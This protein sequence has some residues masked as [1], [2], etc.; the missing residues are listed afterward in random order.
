MNSLEKLNAEELSILKNWYNSLTKRQKDIVI[1]GYSTKFAY[2]IIRLLEE[3]E[4][5]LVE[6]DLDLTK[7]KELLKSIRRGEWT[8]EQI[9]EYFK[10]KEKELNTVYLN[11]TLRH[12]PDEGKIKQLLIECIE[13]WYGD[14]S[15][16]VP[17]NTETNILNDLEQLIK[18]YSVNNENN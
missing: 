5:I 9:K 13:D 2:H 18:K 17:H 11:S 12:S 14:L 15:M 3:S 1:N 8:I 6:Q 4:Q 10:N 16:L 7:S